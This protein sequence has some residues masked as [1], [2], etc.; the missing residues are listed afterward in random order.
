MGIGILFVYLWV[1]NHTTSELRNI[2]ILSARIPYEYLGISL[3]LLMILFGLQ[4]LI[5]RRK[6]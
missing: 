2:S 3:F 6:I 1:S 4:V 5:I